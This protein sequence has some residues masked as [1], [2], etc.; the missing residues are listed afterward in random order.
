MCHKGAQKKPELKQT[1]KKADTG[2][3]KME[4]NGLI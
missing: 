4:E 3:R 2:K 1:N